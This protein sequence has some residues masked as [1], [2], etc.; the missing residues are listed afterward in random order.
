MDDQ[1]RVE[2]IPPKDMRRFRVRCIMA[3]MTMRD[4]LLWCV[5]QIGKG[6]IIL[7]EKGAKKEE[8]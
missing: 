3:D 1:I 6:K 7:P 4:A 8:A 2:K 5:I